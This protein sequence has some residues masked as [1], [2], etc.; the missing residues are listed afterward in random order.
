MIYK[1]QLI[2]GV[3]TGSLFLINAVGVQYLSRV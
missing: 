2:I 1:H 3:D